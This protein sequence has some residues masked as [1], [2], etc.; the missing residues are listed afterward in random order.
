MDF[1][2]WLN[3]LLLLW[4]Y[5]RTFYLTSPSHWTCLEYLVYSSRSHWKKNYGSHQSNWSSIR[6]SF[7]FLISFAYFF[8]GLHNTFS[9]RSSMAEFH[10]LYDRILS[11]VNRR[12][13]FSDI[14]HQ[15]RYD[16]M[17][18]AHGLHIHKSGMWFEEK[19]QNFFSYLIYN[20]ERGTRRDI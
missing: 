5:W 17:A 4:F 10:D 11:I 8:M 7:T 18:L 14:A 12:E 9:N 15:Y 20:D 1:R 2:V 16:T 3:A 13:F 19:Y 6:E